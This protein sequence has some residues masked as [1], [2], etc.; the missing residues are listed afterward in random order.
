MKSRLL[1]VSALLVAITLL[2]FEAFAD[3]PWM[4]LKIS[5]AK[6]TY[7]MGEPIGITI[8]RCNRAYS[9]SMPNRDSQEILSGRSALRVVVTRAD[10]AAV[11]RSDVS[12]GTTPGARDGHN[13]DFYGIAPGECEQ[14]NI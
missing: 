12:R 4:R 1:L 5:T 9:S 13:L 8:E 3:L 10:G 14:D 11:P 2:G 6:S 7:R